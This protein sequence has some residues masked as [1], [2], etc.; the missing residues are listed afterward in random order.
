ML[1]H[2]VVLVK[3]G[4]WNGLTAS[5]QVI[6]APFYWLLLLGELVKTPVTSRKFVLI[7]QFGVRA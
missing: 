4:G 3:A 7:C 2:L 5:N 6:D 1:K